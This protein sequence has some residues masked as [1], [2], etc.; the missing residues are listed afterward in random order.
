MGLVKSK[1]NKSRLAKQITGELDPRGSK[2]AGELYAQFNAYHSLNIYDD[3]A[4][5]AVLV[6]Q[7]QDEINAKGFWGAVPYGS[8]A[9]SPSSVSSCPRS[10]WYKAKRATKD[11][12]IMY[13]YQKR[14]VRNG[15]AIHEA[16]QRDLLYMEKYL[17]NPSFII[18]KTENGLPAWERNIAKVKKITHNGETFYMRG[19]M[20]GILLHLEDKTRIGF[21]YKTKST[22]IA[23]VGNYKMKD[24]QDGHKEQTVAYSILF[25]LNE[26]LIMYESLAKDFWT[27]GDEARSDI[28]TFY[29]RVTEEA[30]DD[31]LD[32]CAEVT[33]A[34]RL[35]EL[36]PK[37]ETKCLFCE[38]K[39]LCKEE[40][41]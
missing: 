6:K 12:L 21:E 23:T 29:N 24:A 41:F 40:K 14:W 20:D 30:K 8:V 26:F 13:P 27:K 22:T 16:T 7:R 3:M 28:R 38:Y 17:D 15:S 10:L 18:D 37:D 32:K 35:D 11:E 39:T 36:P 1:G 9:F 5:E 31:V 2:L 33:R 19:M 4:L 25:D 34:H